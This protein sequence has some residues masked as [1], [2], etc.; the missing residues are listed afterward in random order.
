MAANNA[1][2]KTF[3]DPAF[4]QSAKTAFPSAAGISIVTTCGVAGIANTTVSKTAA[5]RLVSEHALVKKKRGSS[6]R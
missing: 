2:I 5:Q 4:I 1:S 6:Y 3:E